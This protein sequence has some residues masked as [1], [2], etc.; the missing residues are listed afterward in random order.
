M[1]GKRL[2]P[3]AVAVLWSCSTETPVSQGLKIFVT[4][5]VHGAD[6]ANDPFLAGAN[7]IEK[8][9]AFCNSDPARPSAATYKALIVDGVHRDAVAPL[10]W[11]LRP[12]TAYYRV[13]GDVLIGT[14][15][16]TA[17]FGAAYQPL[18]HSVGEPPNILTSPPAFVWTGIGNNV[19]FSAGD[20]C[21]FWSDL[22]N[23]YSA[24]LGWAADTGGSAFG[25]PG[26]AGCYYSQF[27]LYCVEQ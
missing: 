17:I 9:D 27:G 24:N 13:H 4:S 19:D 3:I 15:L 21:N 11:V 14:T 20:H 1:P 10:D 26:G 12:S 22:T 2:L 25:G 16:A 5:R 18:A 23:N 7:A 8:A 6:F